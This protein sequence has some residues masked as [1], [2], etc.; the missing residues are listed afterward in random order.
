MPAGWA[1]A[2]RR[3]SAPILDKL[4]EERTKQR[5]RLSDDLATARRTVALLEEQLR[6]F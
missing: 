1:R 5:A 2:P 6:G 4:R 3:R